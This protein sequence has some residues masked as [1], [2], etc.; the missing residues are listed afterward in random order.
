M[1]HER[2]D[3]HLDKS[4]MLLSR[5]AHIKR[6]KKALEIIGTGKTV[7][8]A[9]CGVGYGSKIL[10]EKNDVVGV[11]I[12]KDAIEYA[13]IN[14]SSKNLD[15]FQGDLSACDFFQHG[16]FDVITH[17]EVLEHAIDPLKILRNFKKVLN[18]S[19]KLIVSVPNGKNAPYN[20]EHHVNNYTP[21]DL[22]KV[23]VSSGFEVK[24]KYGQ[25]PLLG[26]LA[27][28]TRLSTGYNSSTSKKS[29]IVPRVVDSIPFLPNLFS[30]L[31]E[32]D[33]SVSTGRTVYFVAEL[34]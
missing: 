34:V 20:N 22:E 14:Y 18:S 8:D 6:Y 26:A 13:K 28:M 2:I 19:G 5:L 3:P 11:D 31:Y 15:Y 12:S 16:K 29:G 30:N 24:Q 27:E 32:S 7:L 21:S 17:F 1:I 25:Y 33:F 9:G 10:S 23:L 4:V